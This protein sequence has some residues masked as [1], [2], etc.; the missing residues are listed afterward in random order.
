MFSYLDI[1]NTTG[2]F[3]KRI[4]NTN[5]N[6][7]YYKDDLY[8]FFIFC[9]HLK[10]HIIEYIK[11]N[12]SNPH[13]PKAQDVEDF[14]TNSIDLCRCGSLCAITKHANNRDY[15]EQRKQYGGEYGPSQLSG[16]AHLNVP[17]PKISFSAVILDKDGNTL[18]SYSEQD[19]RGTSLPKPETTIE[20][21]SIITFD[22]HYSVTDNE[23][24]QYDALTLAESCYLA[25]T[26]YLNK[27][28][29]L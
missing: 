25:W 22:Q 23:G 10:D 28:D 5:R 21:K 4:R 27:L 13:L 26:E 29:L 1:Y 15:N 11:R 6:N 2:R 24:N 19:L 18:N 20:N 7:L 12:P 3:L 9:Y 17:V 16:T 14:V 8:A